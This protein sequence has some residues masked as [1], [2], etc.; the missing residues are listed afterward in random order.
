MDYLWQYKKNGTQNMVFICGDII[1]CRTRHYDKSAKDGEHHKLWQ[2]SYASMLKDFG[3]SKK[4][5]Y[6]FCCELLHSKVPSGPKNTNYIF[7]ILV[8]NGEYLVGETFIERQNRLMQMFDFIGEDY[9]HWII[10]NN[11]WLAKTFNE[12]AYD[13]WKN[14]N[15]PVDEG[16]VMKSNVPLKLCGEQTANNKSMVKCRYSNNNYAF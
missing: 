11:L 13:S 9:S 8:D 4:G 6:V 15:N 5:W 3:L 12:N 14:I 7:D 1:E 10:S 2:P 16:I